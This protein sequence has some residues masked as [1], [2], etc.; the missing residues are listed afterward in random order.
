MNIGDKVRLLRAKEQGVVSRFL[1]GNMIEI[2]IEDGFRIPVMRS[3]LVLVSPMEAERLLKPSIYE[4]QKTVTPAAPA[5]LSNQGI[6]LAFV[7][8]N[9]REYT[10]HLINNT[11]WEFPYALGEESTGVGGGVQFRGLHSG[12]LKPKSQ[13]KMNDLYAHA[14]FEEWPTFVVQGLWFRAGKSS[15]RQ[16]LMKRFKAR[17]TTLFKSKTTVP[18][19]NQPGFLTQLDAETTEQSQTP[20]SSQPKPIVIRPEELKAEM[21]KSKSEQS[22]VSVERPTAVVDLHIEELL[23]K[24]RN[25]GSSS[26][27]SPADLLKLQLD[28]FEK[29]LENAIASGMSDI[30]F[31]HGVGSGAL[32][33]EL[34][35]RLGKHPNVKFFEDAQK[36]KF[37]YG[38]TKVT[39]K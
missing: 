7:P 29:A 22:G 13:Q 32:R 20:T 12:L 38:A 8:V 37:G 35:K 10:L 14:K 19:L 21:L 2:E 24:G 3:E 28:T 16:P 15:L 11:D 17:A 18:V 33:T 36:Q 9:D 23:P 39:I 1:P 30:T 25:A 26:N 31:I 5:I 27:R 4:P 6:Y 34:H